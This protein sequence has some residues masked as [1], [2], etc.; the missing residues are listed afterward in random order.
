MKMKQ[1][2]SF[3]R[4]LYQYDET[5]CRVR[6]GSKENY[7]YCGNSFALGSPTEVRDMLRRSASCIVQVAIGFCCYSSASVECLRLKKSNAVLFV[8]LWQKELDFA[9][10]IRHCT[11]N[12]HCHTLVCRLRSTVQY[13]HRIAQI[14]YL[15]TLRS[16]VRLNRH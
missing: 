15:M 13:T 1:Q 2:L 10:C 12:K 4:F 11:D 3:G 7:N 5:L 9:Q 14:F 8:F 6:A 16:L